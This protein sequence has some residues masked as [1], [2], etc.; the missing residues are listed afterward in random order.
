MANQPIH[1]PAVWAQRKDQI[2]LS[3]NVSGKIQILMAIKKEE[4]EN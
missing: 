1:A 4:I 2:F 3:F